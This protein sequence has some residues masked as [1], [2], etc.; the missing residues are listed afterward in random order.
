MKQKNVRTKSSLG[1]KRGKGGKT[2]TRIAGAKRVAKKTG[3]R[4]A[5]TAIAK[6]RRKTPRAA[7]NA[8]SLL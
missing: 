5:K 6:P 2:T 4:K 8:A 7:K 3:V 1:S